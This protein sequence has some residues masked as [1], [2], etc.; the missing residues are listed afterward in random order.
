MVIWAV[1]Q[2][3]KR[4]FPPMPKHEKYIFMR[5][6]TKW[7]NWLFQNDLNRWQQNEYLVMIRFNSC[8]TWWILH[9]RTSAPHLNI[10]FSLRRVNTSVFQVR[11]ILR[12]IIFI[13]HRISIETKSFYVGKWLWIAF[14]SWV[15]DD[16]SHF[17]C[18]KIYENR[19]KQSTKR[20]SSNKFASRCWKI[21]ES[22]P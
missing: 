4:Q 8:W 1:N 15:F 7:L 21:C 6:K 18:L 5:I 14:W 22:E 20:I 3:D 11:I 16:Q 2:L 10:H 19:K 17:R 13:L 9:V 12:D